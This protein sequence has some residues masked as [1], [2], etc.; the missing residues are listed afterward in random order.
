MAYTVNIKYTAVTAED[1]QLFAMPICAMFA[2]EGGYADS[3]AYED[4][5]VRIL[6]ESSRSARKS[7]RSV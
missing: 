2:P 1:N 5:L 4:T 7:H 3:A 6:S